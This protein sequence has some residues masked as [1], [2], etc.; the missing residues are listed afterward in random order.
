MAG[1][2][3][4][5][6][7]LF[8]WE[9]PRPESRTSF[10]TE[11]SDSNFAD[12][13]TTDEY[14]DDTDEFESLELEKLFNNIANTLG[15]QPDVAAN[16]T[17]YL[18]S[19]LRSRALRLNNSL[20]HAV[21]S[22]HADYISGRYANYRAW[23]LSDD[24]RDPVEEEDRNMATLERQ[25]KNPKRL[26]QRAWGL[27]Y[28]RIGTQ[29]RLRHLAVYLCIM[30]ESSNLRLIPE[31]M[32]FLFK[33]ADDFLDQGDMLYTPMKMPDG[34]FLSVIKPLYEFHCAQ[35]N[36]IVD[37]KLIKREADHER[38]IGY[39]DIN[40]TFWTMERLQGIKL[41]NGHKLLDLP[42]NQRWPALAQIDW[43]KTL[44]K[45]YKEKR[46]FILHCLVNFSR[47]VA[48]LT[49]MFWSFLASIVVNPIYMYHVRDWTPRT[50]VDVWHL[51]DFEYKRL[52]D[53]DKPSVSKTILW[54]I[55]GLTGVIGSL[56]CF[57]ATLVEFYFIPFTKRN[58]RILA[59]RAFIYLLI[60][61]MCIAPAL[62]LH[63]VEQDTF[64][65]RLLTAI[66]VLLNAAGLA[67]V[68]VIPPALLTKNKVDNPT[69]VGNIAPVTKSQRLYSIV[70]WC[71][72]FLAKFIESYYV[73]FVTVNDFMTALWTL[74]PNTCAAGG[75]ITCFILAKLSFLLM[76]TMLL[77]FFYLDS[78]VWYLIL[79]ALLQIF[80]SSFRVFGLLK[81]E[82]TFSNL[83]NKLFPRLFAIK[84]LP[85]RFRAQPQA[86]C[87]ELWNAIVDSLYQDHL[88][89]AEQKQKLSFHKFET[90]NLVRK[91]RKFS[92]TSPATPS[93]RDS[94]AMP[95][96]HGGSQIEVVHVPSSNAHVPSSNVASSVGVPASVSSDPSEGEVSLSP[97]E[98]Y[99]KPEHLAALENGA[100]K[101][102]FFEEDSEAERRLK[103]LAHTLDMQF[104][105][106]MSVDSTPA[107]TVLIPHYSEKII[108]DFNEI[109]TQETNSTFT[110]LEYLQ[111]LYSTEWE[112][113]AEECR[114]FTAENEAS[115]NEDGSYDA[116]DSTTKGAST[117][118]S[119][120]SGF[121]ARSPKSFS[122]ELIH[123]T[124]L[125]ASRRS[126][127]LYRTVSGMFQYA[128][129][130]KLL[131]RIENPDFCR[132]FSPNNLERE[133]DR[134]IA[135]KF[136]VVVDMQRY[137]DM[138][139]TERAEVE[140]LLKE[141]PAL[142]IVWP[143]RVKMADG[144]ELNVGIMYTRGEF[145]EVIDA[146]MDH[147]L[148]ECIKVRS[149]LA[150]F[151]E[152]ST[153]PSTP[154]V[155]LVGLREHIFSHG[156]GAV[157]DMGATTETTLVSMN[158]PILNKIGARLH[159]GH[160]D[161]WNAVYMLPRGGVSKAQ[162]GLHLNEDIY[163]GMSVLMRGGINKHV[164]YMQVGKGKD[165]GFNSVLAYFS[166]LAMGMSEQMLSREQYRLGLRLPLDRLLSFFYANPGFVLSN[167]TAIV[168]IQTFVLFLVCIGALSNNLTL[169][170]PKPLFGDFSLNMTDVAAN[171]PPV[172]C[173]DLLA[174]EDWLKKI[175]VSFLPVFFVIIVP[176]A[177]HTI[178]ERGRGAF[179]R[180]LKQVASLSVVF[181]IFGTQIWS[182][183]FL[184]TANYGQARY[185]NT[186]RSLELVRKPFYAVY[187]NYSELALRTG[188]L[189]VGGVLFATVSNEATG[190]LAFFW[191]TLIP[192]VI[193]PFW[194]NPHQFR[195]RD[196]FIDYGR[197]LQ[198]FRAGNSRTDDPKTDSWIA[199]HRR[200]RVR[201]SGHLRNPKQ[202]IMSKNHTR[203]ATRRV[204]WIHEILLPFLIAIVALAIYAVGS[205]GGFTRSIYLVGVSLALIAFNAVVLLAIHVTCLLLGPIAGLVHMD[206]M[207]PVAS[208][209]AQGLS[210]I[211]FIVAIAA[212]WLL[213]EWNFRD[214]LLG[215][216]TF[217]LVQRVFLKWITLLLPRE[218]DDARSHL[219]W[220]DGRWYL[221]NLGFRALRAPFR[222]FPCKVVEMSAF[223]NDFFTVHLLL[224]VMSLGCFIPY[225]DRMHTIMVMWAPAAEKPVIMSRA[226]AS[227]LRR[228]ALAN[229]VLFGAFAVILLA[230]L[231]VPML[232]RIGFGVENLPKFKIGSFGG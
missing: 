4:S 147:Y 119:A 131:Q 54:T 173:A 106:A 69:F 176:T 10:F 20:N 118:E 23:A 209:I 174:Y 190:G 225:M 183:S 146:N 41:T 160:P 232:L 99:A 189:L 89:N 227:R 82:Q 148:E 58:R 6:P 220:W 185:V 216:L 210:C 169:C 92:L 103:F 68:V 32:C 154:P 153:S 200:S 164:E 136:R 132:P 96:T 175:V 192:L 18:K 127:T 157:A 52:Y 37:G 187:S 207:A 165:L 161:F 193:A 77:F 83:P 143:E 113:F 30:T 61:V 172:D 98:H 81:W 86:I 59:S 129:A 8:Q 168:A 33:T 138:N 11:G 208:A 14:V 133:L 128:T 67:A 229:G 188:M 47:V 201:I 97:S 102:K 121:D 94:F 62:H 205:R 144:T 181:S 120:W 139:E 40:E 177:G 21:K 26:A 155:A 211:G 224:L 48:L 126:Q 87:A 42:E 27:K 46:N 223:A 137:G 22:L 109:T 12:T 178:I 76:A 73:L 196:F 195:L 38:T 13:A 213:G 91:N 9:L 152:A 215:L 70:L 219:S 60:F 203:R 206:G 221:S 49:G 43:K 194:F 1:K 150:E 218:V 34:Y 108:L 65:A 74:N 141:F 45:T 116:T 19:L 5:F 2:E 80:A 110:I 145:I 90:I 134:K 117:F 57:I 114:K 79:T 55:I 217:Q 197:T 166:K 71:M 3:S 191:I 64:P 100:T 53:E 105:A 16:A 202:G 39:D 212:A 162:R 230:V 107:F 66:T 130:L 50:G 182:R 226:R 151:G 95:A 199:H 78:Y 149:L 184:N 24:L 125:W 156:V 158:Q 31:L 163:A 124:R 123:R 28:K 7:G 170:P 51:T 84:D 142:N 93:P 104:P 135:A 25:K 228:R 35:I 17:E 180:Y 112:N 44:R 56:V 159:Y 198:W 167:V 122:P 140:M 101:I 111:S 88:I 29:D 171:P 75:W 179:W 36:R 72:L 222:E 63:F 204:I 115:G 85:T 214:M 231:I 15:F 186:G